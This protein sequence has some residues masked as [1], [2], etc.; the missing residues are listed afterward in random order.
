MPLTIEVVRAD[1]AADDELTSELLP[2]SDPDLECDIAAELDWYCIRE[3][4][5]F[6]SE[7]IELEEMEE[8][9]GERSDED[10]FNAIVIVRARSRC[11][12]TK[13]GVAVTLL[14]LLLNSF[15]FGGRCRATNGVGEVVIEYVVELW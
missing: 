1:D 3:S 14:A 15:P 12:C 9:T 13:S 11:I 8:L 4:E 6:F 2:T 7:V 10:S 5:R